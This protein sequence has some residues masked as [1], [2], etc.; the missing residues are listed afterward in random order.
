MFSNNKK[1]NPDV[2]NLHNNLKKNREKA[3]FK[4]LNNPYRIIIENNTEAKTQKDLLINDDTKDLN[5]EEKFNEILKD[6]KVENV[7]SNNKSKLEFEN[8]LNNQKLSSTFDEMKSDFKSEY[9]MEQQTIKLQRNKF[10]N[11]IDSLLEDGI[12]D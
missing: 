10:N 5:I 4:L 8:E 12:L 6:R 11:I 3:K 9:E 2:N 1:Y 7:V